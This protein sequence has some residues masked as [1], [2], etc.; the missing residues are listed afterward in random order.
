[1]V[2]LSYRSLRTLASTELT[3]FSKEGSPHK[4]RRET[5][6][7]HRYYY[8]FRKSS[9][10][11]SKSKLSKPKTETENEPRNKSVESFFPR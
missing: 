8:G 3:E 10:K 6:G 2:W 5:H 4:S 9:P 7:L 1:M 11:R